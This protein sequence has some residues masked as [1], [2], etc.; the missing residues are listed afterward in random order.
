MEIGEKADKIGF[1]I[2][3]T[4]AAAVTFYCAY[5]AIKIMFFSEPSTEFTEARA[6][7][8]KIQELGNAG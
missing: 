2:L 3:A 7:G 5:H 8:L 4:A 1:I 6:E